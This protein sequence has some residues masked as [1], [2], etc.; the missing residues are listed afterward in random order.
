MPA[1]GTS[2]DLP[3]ARQRRRG[4]LRARAKWNSLS[5][6]I[7]PIP[8][9]L[10]HLSS[11]P[12]SPSCPAFPGSLGLP[13]LLSLSLPLPPPHILGTALRCKRESRGLCAETADGTGILCSAE[14][15]RVEKKAARLPGSRRWGRSACTVP[16]RESRKC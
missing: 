2:K 11:L 8:A 7:H 4:S 12:P 15:Q 6:F 14:I 9:S 16:I 10:F 5:I 13:F 3:A 1:F